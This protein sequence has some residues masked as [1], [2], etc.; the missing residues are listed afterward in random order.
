LDNISL[1]Q[2]LTVF[3]YVASVTFLI[4]T[5]FVIKL[6]I[7]LSSLAKSMQN[8]IV[9]IKHDLGPTMKEFKRALVNI[10]TIADSTG[11]QFKGLNSAINGGLN[12][13]SNSTKDLS[14][15]ARLVVA[16][17]R[18]GFYAGLKAFLKK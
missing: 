13:L 9:V 5:I 2:A 16:S 3:L 12:V 11:T 7:D 1:Q 14:D 17:I 4:I 8:L 15:R 10:N 6:C 18:Q